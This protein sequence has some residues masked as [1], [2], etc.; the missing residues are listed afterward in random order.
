MSRIINKPI[1]RNT[2]AKCYFDFRSLDSCIYECGT[3]NGG[4]I[5]FAYM[6]GNIERFS[7]REFLKEADEWNMSVKN[8]AKILERDNK[9]GLG[10][11]TDLITENNETMSFINKYEN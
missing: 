6:N 2:I 9:R 3:D 7:R 10:D 11:L 5:Y 1:F 8:T 4:S